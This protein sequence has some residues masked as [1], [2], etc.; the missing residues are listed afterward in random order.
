EYEALYTTSTRLQKAL[1]NFHAAIVRC[2]KHVVEVVSRQWQAKF[3]NSLW[4]SFEQEFRPDMDDIRRCSSN[5]KEELLLAKAQ[6]DYQD[7]QLQGVERK[8]AS[9]YRRGLTRFMSRM[10]SNMD[11]TESMQVQRD[12]RE[13]RE[14]R[15][16]LLTLHSS[17]D[18]LTPLWQS[19]QKRHSDTAETKKGADIF[20]TFFF[21]RFD[22]EQ[23]LKAD[24]ILRSIIRQTLDTTS[25]SAETTAW[26]HKFE[27]ALSPDLTELAEFLGTR[28][29]FSKAFYIVIDGLDECKQME[30][31]EL[32]RTHASLISV[33]PKVKLLI[34]SRESLSRV[35]KKHF[36]GV[37]H[38]SIAC[39]SAQGDIAAYIK[40][41]AEER[42]ENEDLAVR[43]R[44]LVNEI[45]AALVNGSDGMYTH[46]HLENWV[47]FQIDELC[48]THSNDDIRRALQN[49]PESLEE[50]FNRALDRI[51]KRR[52]AKIAQRAFTWIG[53]A[54]RPLSLEQ[55][56][57]V[58]P[59]EIKQPYS[60]PE[61]SLN[62]I[63][64]IQSWCEN[65]I[66]IDKELRI[67]QFAHH[68]ISQFLSGKP[69]QPQLTKF[70][71]NIKKADHFTREI[72][73]TY[74]SFSNFQ[75][76]LT[77]R[78]R[79]LKPFK[80]TNIAVIAL[81]NKSGLATSVSRLRSFSRTSRETPANFE[82]TRFLESHRKQSATV[83]QV[84]NEHPFLAYASEGW[85]LHSSAFEEGKSKTWYTWRNLMMSDNELAQRPWSHT[86]HPLYD[87][88]IVKWAREAKHY[89]LVGLIL[90]NSLSSCPDFESALEQA[91]LSGHDQ[92]VKRLLEAKAEVNRMASPRTA[93][94]AAAIG[95]NLEIFERLLEAG[96][97][98]NV[99][100]DA[101]HSMSTLE[102]AVE[103]GCLD[104]VKRALEAGSEV[105]PKASMYLTP[106]QIAARQGHLALVDTLLRAGAHVNALPGFNG[107]TKL[108]ALA[109]A[110]AG[111]HFAVV[112]R[113]LQEG[114]SLSANRD[115]I[116][117]L[118][119]AAKLGHL[120]VVDSLLEA[121]TK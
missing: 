8:E 93:L 56:H 2:C 103:G 77:R 67:V 110:A 72:Y 50:T 64:N 47:T 109:G 32:I 36:P 38:I 97:E 9:D 82:V 29:R 52:E 117:P 24:T 4:Q 104:V 45:T 48:S 91:A 27:H 19:R 89:A 118:D 76:A 17:H 18:Y 25:L 20:K 75:T 95:G 71:F 85:L 99:R 81:N 43:N 26:L 53:A 66:Q 101:D 58:L 54:N 42:I 111:G 14:R 119:A 94:Q 87:E 46:P 79:P 88:R 114:A 41:T 105:N 62:R 92:V 100:V 16:Q 96:A 65:L 28:M 70:H 113:L 116:P 106:L 108:S 13:A 61:Q 74:L 15:Q 10:T 68:S 115:G 1:C 3:L 49:L 80:P 107:D 7:Q 6:A 84:Q 21:L 121:A 5:V 120:D 11:K 60:K 31:K 112:E 63:K 12:E 44:G 83:A 37:A 57:E 55:L 30:P 69:H 23:S 102:M 59:I 22:D 34:I 90:E 78:S 40:A 73:I 51:L 98:V 33:K 86:Q 35:I 39:Q